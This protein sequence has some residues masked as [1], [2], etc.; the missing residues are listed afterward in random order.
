MVKVAKTQLFDY[1]SSS[2]SHRSK[3]AIQQL[4]YKEVFQQK[5]VDESTIALNFILGTKQ[6]YVLLNKYSIYLKHFLCQS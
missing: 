1:Q 3:V 6:R 4:F 2:K 5:M